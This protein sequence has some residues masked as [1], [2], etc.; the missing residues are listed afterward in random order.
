M[1]R[2]LLLLE[3]SWTACW[4]RME[5]MGEISVHLGYILMHLIA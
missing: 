1:E 2:S 5:L 3:E 4:T